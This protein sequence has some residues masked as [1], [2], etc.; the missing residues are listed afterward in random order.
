MNTELEV[1]VAALARD[2][3]LRPSRT[4]RILEALLGYLMLFGI[5]LLVVGLVVYLWQ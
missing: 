4:R 5:A 2:N 1:A 3:A